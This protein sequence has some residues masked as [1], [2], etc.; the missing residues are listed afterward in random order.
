VTVAFLRKRLRVHTSAP[1]LEF[2]FLCADTAAATSCTTSPTTPTPTTTGCVSVPDTL[3]PETPEH[4]RPGV[5]RRLFPGGRRY[6]GYEDEADSSDDDSY[7]PETPNMICS[8][9]KVFTDSESDVFEEQESEGRRRSFLN[10]E[11]GGH[12]DGDGMGS[13]E[14]DWDVGAFDVDEREGEKSAAEKRMVSEGGDGGGG[15]GGQVAA[16]L[17]EALKCPYR[18]LLGDE[19]TPPARYRRCGARVLMPPRGRGAGRGQRSKLP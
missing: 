2:A 8:A 11:L 3:V 9:D 13:D 10:P 16:E 17:A 1:A 6:D 7:V 12:S 19:A 14:E 5:R 18:E 4:A 15:G